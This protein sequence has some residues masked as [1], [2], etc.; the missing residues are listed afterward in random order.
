[1]ATKETHPKIWCEAKVVAI[2]KP[3]KKGYDPKNYRP[4]SLLSVVYNLFER[5]LLG[6]L[7]RTL[8]KEQA[9]FGNGRNCREQVLALTKHVENG[10]QENLKSGVVFLD[11]SAAY[12]TVWKRGFLLK[13]AK[14]LKCRTTLRL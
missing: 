12:D 14:I 13:L 4:I 9:G 8:P 3:N 6:R 1:M 5:L 7:E 2:L 11:L 10:L